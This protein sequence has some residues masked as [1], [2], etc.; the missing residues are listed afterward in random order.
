MKTK[1]KSDSH[2]LY[3][4]TNG[5]VYRPVKSKNSYTTLGTSDLGWTIFAESEE[6]RI[7]HVS[8]SPWCRIRHITIDKMYEYW[9]S[10][11][12]YI[13]AGKNIN[14]ELCWMPE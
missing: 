10:H 11:G 4:R 9:H 2:G 8:Q 14:S 12:V 5:N 13:V 1:I 6:V 3:V 7:N